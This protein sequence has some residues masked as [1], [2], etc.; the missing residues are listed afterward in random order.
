MRKNDEQ[1]TKGNHRELLEQNGYTTRE[2]VIQGKNTLV[3]GP[4]NESSFQ[5]LLPLFEK[6]VRYERSGGD[7]EPSTAKAILI[8]EATGYF[9][10]D[11]SPTHFLPGVKGGEVFFAYDHP[12]VGAGEYDSVIFV[13]THDYIVK[14]IEGF[15]SISHA[16]GKGFRY[17]DGRIK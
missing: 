13:G 6:F 9:E 3:I 10:N 4:V 5:K 16:Y 11:F 15:Y 1:L 14:A 17:H 12:I 2:Q 7:C 8:G